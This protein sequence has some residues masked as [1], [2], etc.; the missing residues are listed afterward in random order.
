M[1]AVK[2]YYS[3]VQCG[4]VGAGCQCHPE[5]VDDSDTPPCGDAPACDYCHRWYEALSNLDHAEAE[6][7]RLVPLHP[8]PAVRAML[9]QTTTD[10]TGAALKLATVPWRHA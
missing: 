8:D 4:G 6:M 1:G 2:E 3:C 7:R 10:L 5:P 9:W